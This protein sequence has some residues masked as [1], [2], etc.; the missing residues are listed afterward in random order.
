MDSLLTSDIIR[1]LAIQKAEWDF[2]PLRVRL[3]AADGNWGPP[4]SGRVDTDFF[5]IWA[6]TFKE[7]GAEV[8]LQAA[9]FGNWNIYKHFELTDV[10]ENLHIYRLRLN[11]QF[12]YP[13][14][15]VI[16]LNIENESFYDNNEGRNFRVK[17]HGR[18]FTTAAPAGTFIFDFKD[19]RHINPYLQ[20]I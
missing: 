10:T 7:A 18:Y 8:M 15:F 16:R 6:M 2:K 1:T 4:N 5:N 9:R 14:E 3:L 11:G 19:I 12:E 13:D 17:P 20:Q